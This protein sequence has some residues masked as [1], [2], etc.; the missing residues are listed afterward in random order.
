MEFV[1]DWY[2]KS[3]YTPPPSPKPEKEKGKIKENK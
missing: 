3:D 2:V 1:V